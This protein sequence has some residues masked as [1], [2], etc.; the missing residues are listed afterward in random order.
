[1]SHP[2]KVAEPTEKTVCLKNMDVAVYAAV[3]AQA[4][5][6]GVSMQ[7]WIERALIHELA[8]TAQ[9]SFYWAS[10]VHRRQGKE[11]CIFFRALRALLPRMKERQIHHETR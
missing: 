8:R 4:K 1:M 9:D 3:K 2:R 6:D 11:I 10:P 7:K 5:S